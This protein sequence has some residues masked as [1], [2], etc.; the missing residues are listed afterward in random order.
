MREELLKDYYNEFKTLTAICRT[1]TS[2]LKGDYPELEI[3]KTYHMT[4]ISVRKSASFILLSEFGPDKEYLAGCFEIFE[5]GISIDKVYTKDL[6]FWAPCHSVR[7]RERNPN[8]DVDYT[9]KYEIPEHLHSI[10]QINNVKILFAVESGSRAW[11]FESKDSDCDVRFI[12]VHNPEWYFKVEEQRD[13]IEYI[14]NDRLDMV[15]LDLKKALSLLSKSNPSV[16]EWLNSPIVYRQD[17][18]F[19]NR[20]D[21]VVDH[22]INPIKLMYHYNHI[23]KNHNERYL[24]QGGY[25]M[26]RFLYYLRGILACKWIE[27]NMSLPPIPFKELV[28]ATVKEDGIMSAIDELIQVK[29]GEKECD[30]LVVNDALV[31]YAKQWDEYFNDKIGSFRPELTNVSTDAL[32]SILFDMVLL[33][34]DFTKARG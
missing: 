26:K 30:M 34:S 21:G 11:G 1:N 29:R 28:A 14:Y 9:R 19:C 6:R 5:N 3:G 16:L 31:E 7:C 15:G 23:Y 17:E 10:E 22:Y 18:F 32:D 13:T 24:Q 27:L 25:P 20:I 33:H 12:Y 2:W 4:H 8:F